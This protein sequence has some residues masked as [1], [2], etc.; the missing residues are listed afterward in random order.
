MQN[1]LITVVV[2]IYNVEKYIKQCLDSLVNQTYENLEIICVDDCGND[3]SM[4]IVNKY[5]I[6]YNRI[7]I[8]KQSENRGQGEARNFGIDNANGEY[9][10][11]IDSDDFIEKNYIKEL[12]DIAEKEN[13]DLVCN[14]NILKYYGENGSKNKQLKDKNQFILNKKLEWNDKL[15][16]VLPISAWCKLYK[17]DLLKKNKIYFAN[18]KLK[19]EDFYFWYILKNQLKSVYIFYGSTYFYRQRNDSTMSV[20]K[21][22]K[23]DCFDSL[24][25]IELIYKYYKENNVLNKY[26]IPFSWLNKYFKKMNNKNKFFQLIRE[27]FMLMQDDVVDNKNVYSKR[28]LIFFSCILNSNNYYYFKFKYLLSRIFGISYAK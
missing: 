1:K 19:F 3:G 20:N 14:V 21:Y 18:N 10:Y 23:N 27:K 22:N 4:D 11:F 12:V 16:K 26:S 2:P 28:D 7:K 9:I 13:V 15:L 17:T 8:L 5:A 6:E 24:Y 25:I